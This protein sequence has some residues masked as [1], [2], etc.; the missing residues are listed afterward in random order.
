[1]MLRRRF[2]IGSRLTGDIHHE[3]FASFK[4]KA[5]TGI[6]PALCISSIFSPTRAYSFQDTNKPELRF[7]ALLTDG[8]QEVRFE[9]V[10]A[11]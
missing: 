8:E 4:L 7:R 10:A 2:A 11:G 6:E 9:R 1:M 3:R 5:Y